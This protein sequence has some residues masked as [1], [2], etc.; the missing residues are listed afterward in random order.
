M[1]RPKTANQT[2]SLFHATSAFS[3]IQIHRDGFWVYPTSVYSGKTG[4]FGQG[5]YVI[6]WMHFPMHSGI[7]LMLKR[8][9]AFPGSIV[10]WYVMEYV[11]TNCCD[12]DVEHVCPIRGVDMVKSLQTCSKTARIGDSMFVWRQP[13]NMKI[14]GFGD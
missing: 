13:T 1:G 3:A 9:G 2:Q 8:R 12:L 11:R 6:S 5:T 4:L 14:M 10:Q 7:H